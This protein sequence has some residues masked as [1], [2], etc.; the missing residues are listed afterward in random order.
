MSLSLSCTNISESFWVKGVIADTFG[1]GFTG[2]KAEG[3]LF[4]WKSWA[5]GRFRDLNLP[6]SSSEEMQSFLEDYSF[7]RMRGLESLRP[8][9]EYYEHQPSACQPLSTGA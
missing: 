9:A 4:S 7:Q 1:V 8:G 3:L 6:N 2:K 5:L